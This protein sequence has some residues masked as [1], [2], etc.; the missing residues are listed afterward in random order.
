VKYDP[1]K[2]IESENKEQPVRRQK[3]PDDTDFA[4]QQ[5]KLD[6]MKDR[7]GEARD[8]L[9]NYGGKVDEIVSNLKSGRDPSQAVGSSA[10]R[11]NYI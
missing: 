4:I 5:A 9:F 3:A 11:A 2:F 10:N 1:D 8:F 7:S 6:A